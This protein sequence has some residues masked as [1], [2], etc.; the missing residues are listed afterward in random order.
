MAK[1]RIPVSGKAAAIINGSPT[2][3]VAVNGAA[4]LLPVRVQEHSP[5]VLGPRFIDE[6]HDNCVVRHAVPGL[7]VHDWT[8]GSVAQLHSLLCSE[9][10]RADPLAALATGND[11]VAWMT[12]NRILDKPVRGDKALRDRLISEVLEGHN[13]DGSWGAV[14]DTAYGILNLLAL[15][16]PARD[17]RVRRAADWLLDAP[18]P[19]PRPGMWMLAQEL[20]DQWLSLRKP[21]GSAPTLG[22]EIQFSGPGRRSFYSREKFPDEVKPFLSEAGQRMVPSVNFGGVA[23]EPR[24]THVSALAA[25]ALMRSGRASHPRL[26]RYLNTIRRVGG[27]GGYWCGC[28]VMGFWDADLPPCED[29]PDLNLRIGET[30]TVYDHSP[31]LWFLD[32]DDASGL[33]NQPRQPFAGPKPEQLGIGTRLEPFVW[34]KLPGQDRAFALTG[35]A[36]QNA[37]CSAKTNRALAAHPACPGSLTEQLALFHMS[38]YQTSLGDWPEA[39]PHGMLAFLSLYDHPAA[40]ALA[41]KTVPWLRHN[42]K[43]DALWHHGEIARPTKSRASQPVDPRLLTFLIA[44]ALHRFGI[45]PELA[46]HT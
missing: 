14:A 22:C 27:V 31:W 43:D 11:W 13:E 46:P 39:N 8:T 7:S 17:K 2:V 3:L 45:L 26:R 19:P 12:R 37:E 6:L 33:A 28:G 15:G 41:I 18:E 29:E 4:R 24:M 44:L 42:L 9:P 16:V 21:S 34:R 25:E 5:D 10:L 1:G 20:M 35:I 32:A 23:C 40:K 38:R 36:W 30:E